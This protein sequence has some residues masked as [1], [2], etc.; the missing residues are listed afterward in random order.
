MPVPKTFTLNNGIEFPTV[1]L[2]TYRSK[3]GEVEEA[4]K[5]AI[6]AGYRHFDCAW[7]YGNEH[8]IGQ[9]IHSKICSGVIK[10][11][12]VFIGSKL[13]NNFHARSAVVPK[14]K[15]SLEAFRLDYL[16]LYLVHWPM[17]FKEDA[18]LAPKENVQEAFSDVDYLETWQGM[19]DAYKLGLV[20]SIGLSNFNAEQV[21]RICKNCTITP[22]INQVECNP[23]INQKKLI[24]FCRERGV[25]LMG[26]C[27]LG[28]SE[29]S[30]RPGFPE[31][32]IY[33]PKVQEIGKKYNKTGA[34]VVLNYEV[35]NLGI[36]VIPKSVTPSRI[37]ENI[38]IFDFELNDEEVAYLDS[39]DKNK[40]VCPANDWKDHKYFSFNAEF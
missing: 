24:K 13:W 9:A 37:K 14:L 1:G 32:T 2:G 17:G 3:P 23:N 11:K 8:E 34:Q 27:P 39:C 28:R 19:E 20:K 10:R 31:P 7:F 21:D 18:P 25:L 29:Y 12:D 15:E 16:D 30:G 40:R 26:F 33:D 36:F 5:T 22:T 4:V 35:N 6:D 38:D